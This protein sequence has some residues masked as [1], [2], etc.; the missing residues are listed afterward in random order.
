MIQRPQYERDIKGLIGKAAQG[1]GIALN[2]LQILH[3]CAVLLQDKK[4]LS[5]SSTAVTRKPSR[6]SAAELPA[7]SGAY[8]QHTVAGARITMDIMH[9]HRVFQL[10]MP[11]SLQSIVFINLTIE[12][13]NDLRSCAHR[14]F[15]Y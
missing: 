14:L 7:R 13:A 5:T 8:L 2:R 12:T 1:R 9:G 3:T 6:A 15:S 4:L 10:P 11:A